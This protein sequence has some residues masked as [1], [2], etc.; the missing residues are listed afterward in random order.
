MPMNANHASTKPDDRGRQSLRL[1]PEVWT[2]IDIARLRRA[3]S[4]SR[5]TWIT[6]AI[7]EKLA[8]EQD[9][10]APHRKHGGGDV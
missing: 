8:R 2:A 10:G 3:G 4:I 5:N 7:A 6:E 1:D 9:V